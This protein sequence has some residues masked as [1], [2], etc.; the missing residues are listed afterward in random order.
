M[1][2][3][4]WTTSTPLSDEEQYYAD[5]ADAP[6]E[7]W[8]DLDIIDHDYLEPGEKCYCAVCKYHGF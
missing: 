7:Y 2:T 1:D 3:I 6:D 8:E 5:L 4:V